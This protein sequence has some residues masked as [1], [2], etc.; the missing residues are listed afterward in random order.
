[1]PVNE[2]GGWQAYACSAKGIEALLYCR[3]GMRLTSMM[4]VG[5]SGA[6]VSPA[7]G[8]FRIGPARALLALTNIRLGV[9]LP[10]PAY[11]SQS[12]YAGGQP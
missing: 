1:V 2:S 7:M 3:G 6:A 11:A 8:K 5:M 10:N 12:P 4:A 9:W